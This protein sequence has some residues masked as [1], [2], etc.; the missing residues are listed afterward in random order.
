MGEEVSDQTFLVKDTR[1]HKTHVRPV[2]PERLFYPRVAQRDYRLARI[3]LTSGVVYT[4]NLVAIMGGC[5]FPRDEM[6]A[7]KRELEVLR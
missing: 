2:R 5:C 6:N 4:V 1:R 3:S 7:T